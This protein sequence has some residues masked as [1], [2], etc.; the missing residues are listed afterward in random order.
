[1]ATDLNR[2]VLAESGLLFDDAATAGPNDLAI[3]VRA[4]DAGSADAALRTAEALLAEQ[5]GTNGA[6]AAQKPARTIGSAVRRQPHANVAVVSVPGQYAAAEARQALAAGLHVFL[7][8]DNV[9]LDDEIEL[10]RRAR[11]LGLLMMGPDCGTSIINGVGLGFANVVRRG[12]IGLI[13]ASGTGLQEVTTLLDR[14]GA[15][16]SHAIGC[17]G[18]DL[19]DSVGGITTLQALDLLRGDP[20]TEVIVLIS[21]PPSPSVAERVLHAAAATGKQVVACLLGATLEALPGVE[22]VSNLYQTARAAAGATGEWPTMNKEDLPRLRRQPGQDQVRG[23]YCGGTLCEEAELALGPGHELIDFGDDRYTR[24]RAHPMID[25]SLRHHAILAAAE[26]PRV[27]IVLLDV[28]LGFAAHM[29]PAGLL[30]PVVREATERATRAG[31]QLSVLAHVVGSVGDPQ[32]LARQE[33]VLR[34]VGVH[35]FGSNYHAAVA[36]ALVLEQVR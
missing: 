33:E 28:I 23:L 19:H 25:P 36:A 4:S 24:G 10:K 7:F 12:R 20:A 31:R 8:S 15:G 13:G 26:D 17:G 2:E 34:G 1:M 16:V 22:V 32:G 14:A 27:A 21:K 9:S 11:D 30:A 35:L 29:D 6:S 18:R 5:R 3:A